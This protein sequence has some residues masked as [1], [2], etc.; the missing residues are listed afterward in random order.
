MPEETHHPKPFNPAL[1]NALARL[2]LELLDRANG[3]AVPETTLKE[4]LRNMVRPPAEEEDFRDALLILNQRE[5]IGFLNDDLTGERTFF[6]KEKGK[7][8]RRSV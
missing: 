3:Y 4:S 6:L 1:N 2:I 5:M 8:Y 7:A